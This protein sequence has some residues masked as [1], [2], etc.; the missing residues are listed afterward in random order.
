KVPFDLSSSHHGHQEIVKGITTEITGPLLALYEIAHWY[1]T[2]LLL[3]MVYLFFSW[4]P[5]IGVGACAVTYFLEILVDNT[6]ARVKW[7]KMLFPAWLVTLI[8]GFGNIFAL[9]Y[10]F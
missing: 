2:V 3:G 9:C 4:N 8:I 1:E 10:F 7:Q 6:T 5:W